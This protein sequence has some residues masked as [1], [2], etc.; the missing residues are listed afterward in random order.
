LFAFV[1]LPIG[2]GVFGGL[3]AWPGVKLID[4]ADGEKRSSAE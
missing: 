1:I 4:M 2:G 3:L